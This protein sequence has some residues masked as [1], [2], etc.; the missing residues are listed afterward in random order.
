MNNSVLTAYT[1]LLM[2]CQVYDL[3]YWAITKPYNV[4]DFTHSPAGVIVLYYTTCT[5]IYVVTGCVV[6]SNVSVG[7]T[8]KQYMKQ[9]HGVKSSWTS[10]STTTQPQKLAA[11]S[12]KISLDLDD[13]EEYPS[14]SK[15]E[16]S[17]FVG[18]SPWDFPSVYQNAVCLL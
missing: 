14:P 3:M 9:Y 4:T 5:H 1:V 15:S 18:D 11:A 6:L 16:S 10:R 17:C 8:F 2:S 13:F 12:P 7:C